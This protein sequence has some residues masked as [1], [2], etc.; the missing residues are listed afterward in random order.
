MITVKEDT[1][2]VGISELRTH[3]DKVLEESKKHKVLIE[4]RNKPVA[5]LLAMERYKQIEQVLDVL[6]DTAL[7]LLA[8]EREA[9]SRSSD[10]I[11]IQKAEDKITK[12]NNVAD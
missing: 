1:T 9:K 8:R 4:R 10:Y 2:L 12:A 5:V 7:G 11:D 6:E 3:I